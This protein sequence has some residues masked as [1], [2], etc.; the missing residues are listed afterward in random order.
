MKHL[1]NTRRFVTITSGITIMGILMIVIF[2]KP[3]GLDSST[4]QDQ[5][6][7]NSPLEAKIT[8]ITPA[9]LSAMRWNDLAKVVSEITANPEKVL[10]VTRLIDDI[11][12]PVT[13]YLQAL[14]LLSQR[15]PKEAM[16]AFDQ[17]EINAIPADF[18]YAPHRLHQ[19]TKGNINDKY[20]LLLEKAVKD[21]KTSAL[22]KARVLAANGNLENAF[23][24]YL[25]S[26]PAS[27]ASYDLKL[28]GSIGSNQGLSVDLT[29]M[30]TG[31]IASGRVKTGLLTQL[32]QIANQPV[33][34]SEIAGFEERIKNAI[35]KNTPEGRIAIESAKTLLRDRKIFISRQY[36]KLI[37]L[38]LTSEPIKLA[39]ETVL[40]LFLSSV[41]QSNLQQA[42]T[43]GQE[44]KRRHAEAEV[45]VWVNKMMASL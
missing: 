19:A 18:L 10:H 37:K 44:L 20:L 14:L 28:F 11:G 43:W 1:K 4:V 27:W 34:N 35:R 6:M 21:N 9:Q 26:D 8:E 41:D 15:Q 32:K 23:S 7:Q 17:I 24:S 13:L 39:T 5:Y 30:I 22:I 45:K 25:K 3:E 33:S 12:T 40:L 36:Q 29:R 42:E 16:N 2:S 31:A 38:Y